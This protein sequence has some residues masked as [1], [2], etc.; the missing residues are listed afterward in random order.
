MVFLIDGVYLAVAWVIAGLCL[1]PMAIFFHYLPFWKT[2]DIYPRL[3]FNLDHLFS[4][5]QGPMANRH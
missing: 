4:N 5:Y 1:P 2:L 3:A